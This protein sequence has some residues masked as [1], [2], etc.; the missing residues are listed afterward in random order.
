MDVL[1]QI[2]SALEP[3]SLDGLKFRALFSL[4]SI[5]LRSVSRSSWDFG[6]CGALAA[7]GCKP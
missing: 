5:S 7:I 6:N 2:S 1:R 4:L 3:L